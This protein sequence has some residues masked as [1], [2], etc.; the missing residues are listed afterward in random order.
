[1]DFM[2]QSSVTGKSEIKNSLQQAYLAGDHSATR[3]LLDLTELE[4][5]ADQE[6]LVLVA[7]AAFAA[8]ITV[9]AEQ[10]LTRLLKFHPESMHSLVC[11]QLATALA[12]RR[13][14]LAACLLLES[15][16]ATAPDD[17]DSWNDLGS[18]RFRLNDPTA[19]CEAY[20]KALSCEPGF[21]EARYNL[22]TAHASKGDFI[23]ATNDYDKAFAEIPRTGAILNFALNTRFDLDD[24]RIGQIESGLASVQDAETQVAMHFALGKIYD[25]AGDYDRAFPHYQDGNKLKRQ[26]VDYDSAVDTGKE[27]SVRQ[28]FNNDWLANYGNG[29][30]KEIVFIVGLPR[31]GS[32]LV[33]RILSAHSRITAYGETFQFQSALTDV[34]TRFDVTTA[35][36]Y[37]AALGEN[38]QS[39]GDQYS[40][41]ME[42]YQA[43]STFLTDK[44]LH[45]F[46][47]IGIIAAVF[48][49][50]RFV[51]CARDPV[52][53]SFGCYRQLFDTGE[54]WTYDFDEIAQYHA[55]HLRLMQH[56]HSL[57]PG[58]IFDLVH[59]Q[60]VHDPKTEI[61]RLLDFCGLEIEP[62]CLKLKSTGGM[63]GTLSSSQVREPI[64]SRGIGRWRK[65]GQH[66]G[67][68]LQ[69]LGV[70]DQNK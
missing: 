33:E 42:Q 60:L 49:K 52:D 63:V 43:K 61:E 57:L 8:K 50:A 22:A 24:Q 56:W 31:S 4:P 54:P 2:E 6:F 30:D 5:D 38:L 51:Y 12:D 40:Q 19:A 36:E 21:A 11:R 58:R 45:N 13:E 34:A 10:A 68:L 55:L 37:A 48:S 14:F 69:S 41:R 65:Y 16:L 29:N 1:M 59:E 17:A 35:A 15:W 3:I 25:D 26:L 47:H 7:T 27:T 39:I 9:I 70:D 64:N 20:E 28:H 18:H 44:T 32:S 46:W 23:K 67:P 62:A 66:L 53:L